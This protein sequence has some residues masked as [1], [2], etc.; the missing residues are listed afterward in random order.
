MSPQAP[1]SGNAKQALAE[2]SVQAAA[3]VTAEA[4][5]LVAVMAAANATAMAVM[6]AVATVMATAN[7]SCV[8]G[9]CVFDVSAG[10]MFVASAMA[11]KAT[12]R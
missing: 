1:A 12:A 2:T 9:I 6:A 7:N 5:A 3:M 10:A 4:R 8:E 11:V